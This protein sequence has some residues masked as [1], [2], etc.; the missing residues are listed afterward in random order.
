MT[1]ILIKGTAVKTTG[2]LPSIGDKAKHFVLTKTDLSELDQNELKGKNVILNI[3]PSI[4]TPVCSASVRRFNVEATKLKDT[5]VLCVS[6]DLPFAH[7][8]FCAAEGIKDVISVSAFRHADF[9]AN[10]GLLVAEGPLKGL[11][12]RSVVVIDK[13]NTVIYSQVVPELTQEPNYE[14][15][16]SSLS[17]ATE[18]GGTAK[19]QT[20]DRCIYPATAEDSRFFNDDEPCDD[21]R[22]G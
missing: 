19:Q 12:A 10:Y 1:E 21:G 14:E 16:L 13:N 3:F 15:V 6:M 2:A 8:R 4:D 17:G 5:V 11:L 9:N 22:A 7:A 20:L 18:A